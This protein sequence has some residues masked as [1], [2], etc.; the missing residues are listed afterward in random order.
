MELW[1]RLI[2]NQRAVYLDGFIVTIE[3]C[4]IAFVVAVAL[5]LLVCLVRLYVRPLRWLA[6][7]HIEF[8]RSTPICRRSAWPSW[9]AM[10]GSH[11]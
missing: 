9:L 1:R 7:F 5:G 11:C 4:A 10:P 8:C 3:I 2:W 6:I